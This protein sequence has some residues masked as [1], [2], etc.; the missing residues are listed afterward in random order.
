[1]HTKPHNFKH[2]NNKIQKHPQTL[3]YCE[4]GFDFING[5]CKKIEIQPLDITCPPDTTQISDKCYETLPIEYQCP[6]DYLYNNNQCI[7]KIFAKAIPECPAMFELIGKECIQKIDGQFFCEDGYTLRGPFCEKNIERDFTCPENYVY[8]EIHKECVTEIVYE[9]IHVC[10]EGYFLD[11][12]KDRCT[13]SI[14]QPIS[15][16]KGWVLKDHKCVQFAH[17]KKECPEEYIEE[18]GGS[19]AKVMHSE[20]TFICLNGG[21]LHGG[22]CV[23]ETTGKHTVCKKGVRIQDKCVVAKTADMALTCP[24]GYILEGSI[25]TKVEFYDCVKNEPK[26]CYEPMQK[27]D[28]Y[29]HTH[30]HEVMPQKKDYFKHKMMMQHDTHRDENPYCMKKNFQV[31]QKCERV[32]T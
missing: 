21:A 25:C 1:M 20:K 32:N 12:E 2:L 18:T 13:R 10:D 16:E 6:P 7:Q 28:V 14:E 11:I 29:T 19:C 27:I 15:C 31:K 17:K 5:V 26:E 30:A 24:F 3:P 4:E 22:K 9:K 23:Y 8:D